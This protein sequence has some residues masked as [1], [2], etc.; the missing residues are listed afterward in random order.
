[1]VPVF[2]VAD[3]PQHYRVVMG[4]SLTPKRRE[5]DYGQYMQHFAVQFESFAVQYA[6]QVRGAY[7]NL[8]DT[9]DGDSALR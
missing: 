5:K 2:G 8:P 6:E 9:P 7:F 3:D 1:M 4:E